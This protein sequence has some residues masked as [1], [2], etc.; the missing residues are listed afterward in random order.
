MRLPTPLS[1]FI[2]DAVIDLRDSG[3]GELR[4][5][6]IKVVYGVPVAVVASMLI[7]VW[8]GHFNLSPASMFPAAAIFAGALMGTVSMLFT[9]VKDAAAAPKNAVGR[10]PVYQATVVFRTALYCAEVA[11]VLNAALLVA[12]LLPE[13]WARNI[14]GALAIGV[15]THLGMRVTLLLQGLRAQMMNMAGSRAQHPIPRR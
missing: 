11:L 3:Q 5:T 12:V 6:L 7:I 15:F 8:R 9:R 13:G 4:T 10:D 2:A 14:A 1:N